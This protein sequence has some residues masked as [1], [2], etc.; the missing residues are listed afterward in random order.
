MSNLQRLK[1]WWNIASPKKI[2]LFFQWLTSFIPSFLTILSSIPLANTISCLTITDYKS[3]LFWLSLSFLISTL[4]KIIIDIQYKISNNQQKHIYHKIQNRLFEKIFSA[5]DLN[6]KYTSKEKIINTIT[7]NLLTLS[8]F[9]DQICYKTCNL[10]QSFLTFIFILTIDIYIGF[11]LIVF[12]FILFFIINYINSLIGKKT[13]SIQDSRDKLTETFSDIID[14]RSTSLEFNLKS[15]IKEIYQNKVENLTNLYSKTKK[16]L[17]IRDN[18]INIFYSLAIFLSTIHLIKLIEIN[19]ISL[20]TYLILTPYLTTSI[21]KLVDFFDIFN[22]L[23]NAYISALRVKT[24]FDMN[25]KD[26][27]EFGNNSTDNINGAITFSNITYSPTNEFNK[28]IGSINNLNIQIPQ[29]NFVLFQSEKEIDIK[30]IFYMLK[31]V[32]RPDKGTITFDTINIYDFDAETYNKNISYTSNTPYFFNQSILENLKMIEKNKNK[33][34]NTCKKLNIHETIQSLP[35]SYNTNINLHQNLLNSF[36][37]FILSL[38]R[39]VLSKSKVIIV[40][41]TPPNL[42]DEEIIELQNIFKLLKKDHTIL[43]FS[44]YNLFNDIINNLYFIKNGSI[45][46]INNKK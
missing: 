40:Y 43:L 1:Q 18:W 46:N 15:N 44:T 41:K 36:Q 2:L 14:S 35:E 21:T 16:L 17:S 37:L 22:N 26:L 7:N 3:A 34:I 32:I 13:L 23:H 11:F 29:N 31:R 38:V 4:S 25:D 8:D 28:T 33:I 39:L 12:S 42:S 9:C 19:S 45:L 30:T 27:I 5:E 10:I 20:N 6:F 24:L